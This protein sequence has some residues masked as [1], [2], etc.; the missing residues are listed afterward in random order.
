MPTAEDRLQEFCE[1]ILEL[2]PRGT[3]DG[4]VLSDLLPSLVRTLSDC[5][6]PSVPLRAELTAWEERSEQLSR[7]A[8]M[9]CGDD[10]DGLIQSLDRVRRQAN[11]AI[12]AIEAL[13]SMSNANAAET[14]TKGGN[15]SKSREPLV[16][17]E[18]NAAETHLQT[19]C[20]AVLDLMQAGP[21]NGSVLFQTIPSFTQSFK[22][23]D[24]AAFTKLRTE[25]QASE[26]SADQLML[27]ATMHCG[28]AAGDLQQ[29]VK[30]SQARAARVIDTLEMLHLAS[31]AA[32]NKK[33]DTPE[34]SS[35]LAARNHDRA[36]YKDRERAHGF[37]QLASRCH[38]QQDLETA[39]RLYSETLLLDRNHRLA[40]LHRGRIR[41]LR[42]KAEKAIADFTQA[43]G[44]QDDDPLTFGWRGDALA[45]CGRFGDALAD[46]DR[47]LKL[48]PD[49]TVVRYNRAVVLRQNGNL[50]QAWTE[51]T[52]L[53][54]QKPHSAPLY[55]NRGLIC[56]ARGQRETAIQEFQTAVAYQPD[57]QEALDRLRELGVS[58][59]ESR[60]TPDSEP[61]DRDTPTTPRK[62]SRG[63]QRTETQ[64][65]S[66]ELPTPSPSGSAIDE[67]AL[68]ILSDPAETEI[69]PS[70]A[71]T[72]VTSTAETQTSLPIPLPSV[73]NSAVQDLSAAKGVSSSVNCNIEIECP[74]CQAKS[75]VRWDRL[76]SGKVLGCPSCGRYYTSTADGSL[77]VVTKNKGG[78]MNVARIQPGQWK[79]YRLIG[80]I[81]VA[82][83]LIGGAIFT[84]PF[85]QSTAR[86]DESFPRELE[87]RSKVFA[88]AWLKGDF[89]TMRQLTDPIQASNLFLWCMENP[90]P[91]VKVP[92]TLERDVKFK[93]VLMASAPPTTNVQVKFDGLQVAQGNPISE[94]PPLAWKQDGDS[95]LFQPTFRG[96]M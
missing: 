4:S 38:Q 74:A 54:R 37:Y 60:K 29:K 66:D 53:I 73:S 40:Y 26:A 76:Q 5:C 58:V 94:L 7:L 80:S 30:R 32:N 52:Q 36:P 17:G 68:E 27:L 46:Y 78:K 3:A 6:H 65:S 86:D 31:Y 49:N 95:W 69:K 50:D 44:L 10:A 9:H 81:V 42:G 91:A 87:P 77:A 47:S 11:R 57:S 2:L 67:L 75:A 15:T 56:L 55:L 85:R 59:A 13:R 96:R 48:F 12:V 24:P 1:A 62:K 70:Q 19:L 25:L 20:E 88:L 83:L 14:R 89:K 79:E 72:S 92:A 35:A 63:Q 90:T 33:A 23:C 84:L 34:T 71:K 43:L 82:A 39:E 45:L 93:I 21:E 28:D 8:S 64:E 16:S 22:G 18:P 51:L 41:L 61:T